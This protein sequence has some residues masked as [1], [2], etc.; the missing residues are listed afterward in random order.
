[1]A[2]DLLLRFVFGGLVVCVFA[3]FGE[4]VRPQSLAGIFGAA[5]TVALASLAL[6]FATKGSDYAAIE[7]R[8]MI[9]GA[10]ALIIYSFVVGRLLIHRRV[11]ALVMGPGAWIM[12]LGV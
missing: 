7:G 3:I 12:W 4:V 10:I 11:S 5:P 1:M 9:F 6:A 2:S 8:S